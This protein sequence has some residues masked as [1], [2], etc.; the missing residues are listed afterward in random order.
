MFHPTGLEKL[1][2]DKQSSLLGQFFPSQEWT[3]QNGTVKEVNCTDP[4]LSASLPCFKKQ[5]EE[6]SSGSISQTFSTCRF[7]FCFGLSKDRLLWLCW[8]WLVGANVTKTLYSHYLIMFPIGKSVCLY[9][10][11]WGCGVDSKEVNC[12]DPSLSASLPRLKNKW[13][14][15]L[16]GQSYKLFQ[17]LNFDFVSCHRK[18]SHCGFAEAGLLTFMTRANVINS[19]RP[20]FTSVTHR[21]LQCL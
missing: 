17:I 1:A 16:Y 21:C 12:T 14:G 4:S 7:Q 13:K 15:C 5:M 6:T 9:F 10:T 18:L 19:T 8:G 20:Q 11:E 3:W 2:R